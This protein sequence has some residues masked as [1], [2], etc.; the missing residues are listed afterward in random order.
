[1]I[2]TKV[3]PFKGY[4]LYEYF[5]DVYEEDKEKSARQSNQHELNL[6]NGGKTASKPRKSDDAP[7]QGRRVQPRGKLSLP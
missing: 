5:P 4:D 2:Q 1:M 6:N 7:T 3:K